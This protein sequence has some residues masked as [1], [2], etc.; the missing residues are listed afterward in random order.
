M[1]SVSYTYTKDQ[2]WADEDELLSTDWNKVAENTDEIHENFITEHSASDGTHTDINCTGIDKNGGTGTVGSGTKRSFVPIVTFDEW[3]PPHWG[4]IGY[5]SNID[6]GSDEQEIVYIGFK[7]PNDCDVTADITLR[8]EYVMAGADSGAVVMAIAYTVVSENGDITP[9]D[10]GTDS[11]TIDPSD[12]EDVY[13]SDISLAIANTDLS[14]VTQIVGIKLYR[15]AANASDTHKD[16]IRI[17]SLEIE[18][19]TID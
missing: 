19:T 1:M 17:V 12:S 5:F 2:R 4:K 15:D 10:T 9:A 13:E 7:V 16:A 18:Y 14:A 8:L 11:V 6:F 3:A